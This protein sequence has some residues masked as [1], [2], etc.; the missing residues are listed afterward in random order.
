MNEKRR[1]ASLLLGVVLAACGSTPTT[2][3]PAGS[4]QPTPSAPP[5][6]TASPV[7]T[8]ESPAPSPA[9]P[10]PASSPTSTAA[11]TSPAP[12]PS[13]TAG[14]APSAGVSLEVY[15]V[16][17][18]DTLWDIAVRHGVTLVV[19]L[20]ANPQLRDRSLIHPGDRIAIP[21]GPAGGRIAFV[22]THDGNPE[23]YTVNP[24]GSGLARLTD[25][26]SG[27]IAPA[28][29]PDGTR[30]AF[31]C[32][33]GPETDGGIRTVGPSDI[34]VMDADGRRLVRLTN[35]P[36]SDGEPAWSPDGGRIAFRRAADIYTMKPDGTE[37]TRLTTDDAAS[38]P[39]WSPD[40][41]Q[42]VFTSRR[43]LGPDG[44]ANPEIYLMNADGTEALNLTRDLAT[45]DGHPAWSPD[46]T[47][48][49]YDSYPSAGGA[50][51]VWLM[52]VDGSNK[53]RLSPAPGND[54]EPAWSPD[55]TKIAFTR[56]GDNLGD[57]FV[58]NVDG[59][60]AVA[61]TNLP[62]FDQSPDWQPMMPP[63]TAGLIALSTPPAGAPIVQNDPS[64][65]CSPNAAW[66]YGHVVKFA[67]TAPLLEG[68]SGYQLVVR[69]IDALNPAL[70]VRVATPSFTWTACNAFVTDPN[71]DN[72]HWQVTALDMANGVIAVSEQRAIRFL[73]CRLADG[74]T[75]CSAPG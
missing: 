19:L 40:G 28:W 72:W 39:A 16:V 59:T 21:P 27:D 67:W 45:E 14:A 69:H 25:S 56:Y 55:G 70:D 65:G 64:T 10:P 42:I 11:P 6:A 44:I 46:G 41:T 22:S 18:G 74:K 62:G 71:L 36:V 29:S 3:T 33:I 1:A 31:G 7:A 8:P 5:I 38:E 13:P 48:I 2:P 15:V 68:V 52:D 26:D 75:A 49:A 4:T 32:G 12:T 17:A 20:A 9:T 37:I 23:I 35:D 53:V 30:I 61:V 34:C 58:R 73:P 47:R 24:D 60:G 50:V 57:I 51:A 66:G 43:D 54:S 63:S